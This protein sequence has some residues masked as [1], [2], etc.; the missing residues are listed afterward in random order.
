MPLLTASN[1]ALLYAELEVFSGITL[2][3]PE[4]ARIGIVGPNGGGKTS[5]MRVLVGELAPNEGDV[6]RASGLRMGYVAQ[7]PPRAPEGSLRDEVMSAFSELRVL[8]E[9][10]AAS[11]LEIQQSDGAGLTRAERRYGSLL[12]RYEA[13][14]GYDYENLMERVTT[15]VGLPAEV[16]ATPASA[17]SGGERTRA[18][19]ATALLTSP[20]LLLLD[21]P[22]NYLDFDGLAWLEAFL[23]RFNQAF[24][25]VSHDRYFLDKV[26]DRVWE[27]E[28]GR[29][30]TFRGNFS[31]FQVLRSEQAKRRQREFERQREYIEKEE[32]F[33]RRYGA[34]QRARE[35]RGRATRLARLERVEAPQRQQELSIGA[36]SAERT[37]RVVLSTSGLRVGFAAGGVRRELL[38][39]PDL[40]LERQSRTAIVGRNGA[41]KSTL[42]ETL[43]GRSPALSGLVTRGH[44]VRVGYQRQGQ[45]DLPE[46]STV[47]DALLQARNMDLGD[48][49]SYLASFLFVGD[50]VFAPVS[51]L[52]GGERTRLA[53][54]RL[55]ATGPNFLV[56]D[57]PT[58]HLDIPS[59][60]ALEGVLLSF[61][62]TILFV[63][64]D[65]KLI[66]VLAHQM[67]V[68]EDGAVS[69][70]RGTFEEWAAGRE[71]AAKPP[72][73]ARRRSA[74]R[75]ARRAASQ[76]ATEPE[77]DIEEV[78]A[79]LERRLSEIEGE[80]E[81]AAERQDVSE[82]ARLGA[83]YERTQALL[84]QA[85]RDWTG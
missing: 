36:A 81:A 76:P 27:L 21:E 66:S 80:L 28:G 61:D 33:I 49:R 4:R 1:L 20:D 52:S 23:E 26:V 44:N 53:L 15:G 56:L 22:T 79:G 57:E 41:G 25:V 32:A 6:H 13:L 71:E 63:S 16:L 46:A 55:L 74:R 85:L 34:G 7:T 2:E 84:D 51:S 77:P 78:I 43:L 10:L 12:Q 29:L 67:W 72:P 19:L 38:S 62:G 48:A 30:Q 37:G 69:V 82:I 17:A 9:E 47:L 59:R 70:F 45:Y 58:T 5:L 54:A 11:A 73:K 18:A 42:V 3:V 8:E 24:V 65:R 40:V 14:G 64:H 35:A 83:E 75:A 39:V 68:I 60:E 50:D 31:K